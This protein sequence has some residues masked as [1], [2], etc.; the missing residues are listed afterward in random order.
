MIR[1]ALLLLFASSLYGQAWPPLAGESLAGKKFF[2]PGAVHGHPAVLVVCFTHASGPHCTEATRRLENDFKNDA[3]L[4]IYTLIF[5]AD[6]PKLVR[7]MARS[8]IRSG[9]SKED[10]D[11]YLTVIEG[12]KEVKSVV[13][14][15]E[16]DDPYFAVLDRDGVVRWTSHG[17]VNDETVGKIRELVKQP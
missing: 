4:E 9:V 11:H 3:N 14:F 12:E 2:M 6:A 10:Y 13:H 8:G 5:L 17:P 1:C 16:P 7:G 15:Q